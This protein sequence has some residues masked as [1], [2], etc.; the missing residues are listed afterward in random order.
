M[1]LD[2]ERFIADGQPAWTELERLLNRL[3]ERA[4]ERLTLEEAKRLHYLYRRAAADLAKVSTFAAEPRT[5]E[6]LEALVA[7]AYSEIHETR[8]TPLRFNPFR[9]FFGTFPRTFRA[10]RRAFYL[11]SAL[12]LL[13][14]AFG[15]YAVQQLSQE[16]KLILMPFP[17]LLVD[18]SERVAYEEEARAD[19][20][21]GFRAAFSSQLM[22]HN[23]R[24]AI[25]TMAFGI[26]WGIGTVIL[27]FYNGVILGAVVFDY[28]AAGESAFLVGWLLP[29]GAV[30]IPA[31]LL[32]GQAGLIIAATLIGRGSTDGLKTRFRKAGPVLV[33]I[34]GG[35]AVLLIWAGIVEA[36]FSQYHEP[37]I[38]YWLKIAFGVVELTLL[39]SFLA[40]AGRRRNAVREVTHE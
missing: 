35:A 7:R 10:H 14:C 21:E 9:W 31:I 34:I 15:G 17:H 30:E 19:R 23:T 11:S 40:F 8:S 13:G 6:Y 18:P 26:T 29:H 22:T 37:T 1:I 38:P 39:V 32:G 24:V 3:E 20:L 4:E 25:T 28:V 27:L 2:L 36:F 12:L 5:R 33:T 16:A